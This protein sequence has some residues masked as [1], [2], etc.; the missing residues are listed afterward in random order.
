[1]KATIIKDNKGI[2]I[3][4]KERSLAIAGKAKEILA[5]I[6]N[7]QRKGY[8]YLA[9]LFGKKC[10]FCKKRTAVLCRVV[11][12]DEPNV[13][14]RWFVCEECKESLEKRR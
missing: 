6:Q 11:T 8:V 5:M 2:S 7:L 14:E 10:D 4:T 12:Q 1:M 3:D 9:D 13:K